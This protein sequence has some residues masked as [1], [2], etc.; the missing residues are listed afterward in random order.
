MLKGK[1]KGKERW[2][3]FSF[4]SFCSHSDLDYEPIIITIRK[5]ITGEIADECYE[6]TSD[7]HSLIVITSK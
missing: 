6:L 4:K 3:S 7:H 2:D 5:Q 1:R